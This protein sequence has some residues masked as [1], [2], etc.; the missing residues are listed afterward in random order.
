MYDMSEEST[1]KL[2]FLKISEV[3]EFEIKYG[4]LKDVGLGNFAFSNS[5]KH[6]S[7]LFIFSS[8]VRGVFFCHH[9]LSPHKSCCKPCKPNSTDF[10]FLKWIEG[11][12]T[13]SIV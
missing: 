11:Q 7:I 12:L 6:F 5:L 3:S 1:V 8:R 10:S 2:Y 13:S 9:T 4:A